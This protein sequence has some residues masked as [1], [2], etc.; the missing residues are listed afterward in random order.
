MAVALKESCNNLKE[1]YIYVENL[2]DILYNG[3]LS[4][5]ENAELNGCIESRLPGNLNIRFKGINGEALLFMLDNDGICVST[6]S[7]CTSGSQTPS[8]VLTAIGLNENQAS[9]SIRFSL[10]EM[11]T[12]EEINFVLDSLKKNIKFLRSM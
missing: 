6:S 12:E 5:I 8:H 10:S 11:N 7:A 1:N 9:S 3:I 2:K 4:N